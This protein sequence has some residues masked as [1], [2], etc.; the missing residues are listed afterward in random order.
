MTRGRTILLAATWAAAA[1]LAACSST[2]TLSTGTTTTTIVMPGQH[3]PIDLFVH[4]HCLSGS[5]SSTLTFGKRQ[6]VICVHVGT[7][8][9]LELAKPPDGDHWSPDGKSTF[10]DIVGVHSE[11]VDGA[12]TYVYRGSKPG[13]DF[14][15]L[16]MLY[17]CP[18]AGCIRPGPAIPEAQWVI[19][20][21]KPGRV[22]VPDVVRMPISKAMRTIRSFGLVPRRVATELCLGPV[23]PSVPRI[24][25]VAEQGPAA[26]TF[27]EPGSVITLLESTRSNPRCV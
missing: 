22:N 19:R 8:L 9:T 25:A 16:L 21:V 18:K 17:A 4:V 13:I 2:T 11:G 10:G 3:Q 23:L 27:V 12:Y 20:V 24:G 1:F 15:H 26:F 7:M 14:V 5:A 6:E